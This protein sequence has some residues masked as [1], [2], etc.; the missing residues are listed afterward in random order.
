ML[1]LTLLPSPLGHHYY[2]A[3]QVAAFAVYV[4][5]LLGQGYRRG[6]AQRA[7]LPLVAAATLGLVLGCQLVFLPL[8]QWLGWLRGSEVAGL[9]LAAGPRSVIGGAW[10]SFLIVL[11]LGRVLGFRV[12]A[13]LDAFAAP[14]CWALAVQSVGCVL[15]GCCWGETTAGAWGVAYGPGSAAYAAQVALGQLPIGAAHTHLLV[16][17]QLLQLLLCA[18]AGLGLHLLRGRAWPAGSRYLLGVGLLCLGRFVVEFWRDPAGEP[19]LAAPLVLGGVALAGM[20]WLMLAETLVLLG[21]W[22]WL[23]RRPAVASAA[24]PT[25][26]QAAPALV[27]LGLLVATTRLAPATL[28]LAE[29]ATLQL[30]LLLV[31]LAEARTWLVTLGRAVP[32][33]AGLPLAGLL[34]V[35]LLLG[36]AQAPAPQRD[37]VASRPLTLTVGVLGNNHEA[38]QNIYY[39]NTG[40]SGSQPLHMQQRV[41]AA[42]AEVSKESRS[43]NG[44]VRTI[45]GGVWVGQQQLHLRPL[46]YPRSVDLQRDT[47]LYEP[48]VA[49]HL[50]DE[51][52]GGHDW[53]SWRARLGLHAGILGYYSYFDDGNARG[54]TWLMPEAMISLGN[55]RLL[56]GQADFN[57]GT[58][59]ALG[60]YTAR[61][62]LGSGLG[63]VNGSRVLAGYAHSPHTP[64]SSLAFASALLRLPARTGLDN[65]SL[66]PYFATNFDRHN[67]FS[68]KLHYRL[69]TK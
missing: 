6:Y 24:L 30:L 50:Y 20:Q 22:A 38:A 36:T 66:E 41:R 58:E 53:L 26:H 61:L 14:L 46:A 49:F 34:G 16:P 12:R 65:L 48:L 9:A 10:G 11:A 42:G 1:P 43:R 35:V 29:V 3:A 2:E 52:R 40:C 51:A 27:A 45:G 44:R 17:T 68:L 28:S 59:N 32:R 57:Y 63:Q 37:S 54:T 4:L 5:L 55:P 56:Y 62:G 21:S 13:V 33:L 25:P 23:I 19:L 18:G 67:S 31:L 60:A 8:G 69:G 7:W 47:T 15:A 39:D 64:T